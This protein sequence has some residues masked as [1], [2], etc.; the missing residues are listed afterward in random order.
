MKAVRFDSYG[1][2]DVLR[3]AD[4]PVPEPAQGEAL[5]KVKAASINP[6]EAKIRE[7]L[8]H[9][10]WSATFPSDQGSD[11]S[12]IVT[13]MGIGS[14][15]VKAMDEIIGFTDRRASHAEYVVIEA[16]NLTRKPANVSW[17]IAGALAI[18]GSTAYASVRALSLKGVTR[19]RSRPPRVG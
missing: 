2:I 13:K 14:E 18:A 5:V 7:E 12:G 3:L 19:L 17:E 11:L 4:V 6:G 15:G 1:G 9:A 16:Q 10:R 8:F